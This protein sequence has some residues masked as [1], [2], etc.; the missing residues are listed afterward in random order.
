[1]D[2]KSEHITADMKFMTQIR[3]HFIR[4]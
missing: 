1:M 3:I 2:L 4:S